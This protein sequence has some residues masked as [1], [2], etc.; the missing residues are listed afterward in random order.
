M[1]GLEYLQSLESWDFKSP[2]SQNN[3]STVLDYLGKPQDKPRALH[4]AGTNG[5][6]SVSA[7]MSSILKQ[8]GYSV[9]TNISPHLMNVNERF[10]INGEA[11]DDARL[12]EALSIVKGAVEATEAPLSYHEALTAAAFY[13]FKDLDWI[14]MEVGLGGRLDASNVIAKPEI[15][16]ITSIGLDHQDILGHTL[17]A[18]AKEK[19]GIIK[20]GS[21]V[22]LG[23]IAP[24]PFEVISSIC[25][26][27]TSP[28]PRD[29]LLSRMPS[30]A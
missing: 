19:A 11:I 1:N 18:I 9:G 12:S 24:E 6:G 20:E 26:L 2:F 7:M 28:S 3:I 8:A 17:E 10:I 22:V 27:Y 30:S 29:G 25:L 4:V 5:K 21:H 13:A 23:D 15:A 14:V 16:F